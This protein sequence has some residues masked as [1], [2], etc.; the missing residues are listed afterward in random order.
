MF[1]L[2][3]DSEGK[4][5][6]VV[7]SPAV[8]EAYARLFTSGYTLG[9]VAAGKDRNRYG[10]GPD[11]KGA[12]LYSDQGAGSA[13]LPCGL[14]LLRTLPVRVK[15][16]KRLKRWNPDIDWDRLQML[17]VGA[18]TSN[19]S[20]LADFSGFGPAAVDIA[21]PGKAI[22]TAA[23][24]GWSSST[25]IQR[26]VYVN[27]NGT[28]FSSPIVA[29]AASLLRQAAPGAPI[30]AIRTAL[31]R[32]ARPVPAL[33][34]KVASGQLD[35]ACSLDWLAREARRRRADWDV[36]GT[37]DAPDFVAATATCPRK[38][39]IRIETTLR[40]AKSELYGDARRHATFAALL[41]AKGL[42]AGEDSKSLAW[43][44][45]ML[46]ARGLEPVEGRTIFAIG[47]PRVE[48]PTGGGAVFDAGTL[49]L[50]CTDENFQLSS[51]AVRFDNAIKPLGWFYPT[52]TAGP[53]KGLE[54]GV[55]LDKPW[56]SGFMPATVKVVARATCTYRPG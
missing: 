52:D 25:E 29:G 11:A 47:S 2:G 45:S 9:V 16:G 55:A 10:T 32:G 36:L 54:L 26:D 28:S 18:T 19:E 51:I 30:E 21:A 12:F 42:D 40:I 15:V 23:R 41:D 22:P 6:P 37:L 48:R 5:V 38:R 43:Q 14:R 17:C 24:P 3:R 8:A 53:F 50:V 49:V 46:R 44:R 34:G 39:P 20:R 13:S 1:D 7:N 56:Y 33:L 4:P 35:V 27:E 31:L